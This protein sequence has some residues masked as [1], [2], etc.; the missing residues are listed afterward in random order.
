MGERGEQSTAVILILRGFES[1][2]LLSTKMPVWCIPLSINAVQSLTRSAE[3]FIDWFIP[4]TFIENAVCP[5]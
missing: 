2:G 4:Q 1:H 5:Q 3:E